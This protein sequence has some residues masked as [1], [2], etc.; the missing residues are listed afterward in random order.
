MT[1]A[2]G[3]Q[4]CKPGRLPL[5]SFMLQVRFARGAALDCPQENTVEPPGRDLPAA[6]GYRMQRTRRRQY[7][8]AQVEGGS[9]RTGRACRVLR[10]PLISPRAAAAIGRDTLQ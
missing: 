6:I 1:R 5:T 7:T 10:E 9:Y 2:T 4:E 8:S 3:P